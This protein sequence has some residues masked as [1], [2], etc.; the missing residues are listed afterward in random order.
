MFVLRSGA[1]ATYIASPCCITSYTFHSGLLGG[2]FLLRNLDGGT[3][4]PVSKAESQVY[5]LSERGIH[6]ELG[7]AAGPQAS[8]AKARRQT[9]DFRRVVG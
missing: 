8:A 9:A 3:E 7:A 4:V 1:I 6:W 2:R 5:D